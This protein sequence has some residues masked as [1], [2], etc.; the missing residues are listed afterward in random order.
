MDLVLNKNFYNYVGCVMFGGVY[1]TTTAAQIGT[2]YPKGSGYNDG[3]TNTLPCPLIGQ[4]S[5]VYQGWYWSSYSSKAAP[6]IHTFFC[7]N[8]WVD[9]SV[10]FVAGSDNTTATVDD[11]SL[12]SLNSNITTTIES[13]KRDTTTSILY[14]VNFSSSSPQVLG[15]F[16]LQRPVSISSNSSPQIL[17]ARCALENPI[18]LNEDNN[19]SVTLQIR[20]S[21]SIPA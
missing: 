14:T 20:I 5:T 9:C 10:S 19:Y 13:G 15:E 12:I 7:F 18:T 6:W 2:G 21:L 4:D 11:T 1:Q 16:G 3:Y 17:F 8:H